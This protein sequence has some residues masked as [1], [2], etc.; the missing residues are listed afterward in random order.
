MQ[1][2][3]LNMFGCVSCFC[4]LTLD[5]EELHLWDGLGASSLFS[6]GA[7]SFLRECMKERTGS[8]SVRRAADI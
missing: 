8:V 5:F 2:F 6:V 7:I 4:H 3:R 1:I